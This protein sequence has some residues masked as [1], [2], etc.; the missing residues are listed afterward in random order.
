MVCVLKFF[1]VGATLQSTTSVFRF[2]TESD[3]YQVFKSQ[4]SDK[5]NDN[6]KDGKDYDLVNDS[7]DA[8]NLDFLLLYCEV[9]FVPHCYYT[10]CENEKGVDCSSGSFSGSSSQKSLDMF[11]EGILTDCVVEVSFI[12]GCL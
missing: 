9:E 7:T 1:G 11:K 10:K 2:D 3:K 12:F 6:L 8:L 4:T 5:S